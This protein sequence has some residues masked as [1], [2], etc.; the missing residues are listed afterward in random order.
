MKPGKYLGNL[1][2]KIRK[3]PV[4][5]VCLIKK[6]RCKCFRSISHKLMFSVKVTRKIHHNF[7]I[8]WDKFLFVSQNLTFYTLGV[9]SQH[10]RP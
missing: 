9:L 4:C 8:I 10:F 6:E 5:Y 2:Y 3:Q 1:P 7:E